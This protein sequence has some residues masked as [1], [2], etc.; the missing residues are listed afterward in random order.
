MK[1][2]LSSILSLFPWGA[3]MA[4]KI[5]PPLGKG[6]KILSACVGQPLALE[7]LKEG[8]TFQALLGEG[9]PMS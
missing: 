9:A 3:R 2:L 6:A 8:T 4:Y 5:I 1:F 7:A